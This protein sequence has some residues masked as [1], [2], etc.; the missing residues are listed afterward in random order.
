MSSFHASIASLF[1]MV[2]KTRHCYTPH[3]PS[4]PCEQKVSDYLY[5]N[6]PEGYYIFNDLFLPTTRNVKTAQIDHI[7]VSKY[8][9]FCIETKSHQGNIYGYRHQLYWSQYLGKKRFQ[10]LNPIMQNR[11]HVNS[12][13][14]SLGNLLKQPIN[15][16]VVFPNVD[17][18]TV[19][20]EPRDVSLE[21]LLSNICN[22]QE[23]VYTDHEVGLICRRLSV[24]T[25]YRESLRGAHVENIRSRYPNATVANDR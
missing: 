1:T 8:G 12:L 13:E 3:K 25:S 15:R 21:G 9:V 19:D 6:L 17:R 18:L 5:R 16:C 24:A 20:R 2:S 23:P 14:Y 11:H 7:V 4:D 10:V 22:Y